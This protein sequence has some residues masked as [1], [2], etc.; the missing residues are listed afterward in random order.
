MG[1]PVSGFQPGDHVCAVYSTSDDLAITVADFL[2]EGLTRGERCWYVAADGE[3][4]DVRRELRGRHM[5]VEAETRRR[6]L[7]IVSGA[8]AYVVRGDFDPER[9]VEVFNDAIEQALTDG[10]TGFRAAA[11]MSWALELENGPQRLIA[12][13]ALLRSLFASCR[14]TGLC[15]Y[16]QKRMPLKVLN[17][18]LVTHPIASIGGE[19]QENPFYEPAVTALPD[20]DDPIVLAKLQSLVRPRSASRR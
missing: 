14:V 11:D 3:S 19:F 12:Y 17:G 20:T 8:E 1:K 2:T 7:N 9:T 18:A 4:H 6:A 16:D 13:E 10:F 5:N 15:L